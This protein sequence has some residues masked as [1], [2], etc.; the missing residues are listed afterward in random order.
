MKNANANAT[1]MAE[2]ARF[3]FVFLGK[4]ENAPLTA[5]L[6]LLCFMAW[7]NIKQNQQH[8]G[9][10]V[11]MNQALLKKDSVSRVERERYITVIVELRRDVL[12]CKTDM[13]RLTQEV[14]HLKAIKK[15]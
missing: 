14:E 7:W 15:R 1:I 3:L 9:E 8:I 4:R 12:Q 6:L 11:E 10:R 5:C 13:A 2:A